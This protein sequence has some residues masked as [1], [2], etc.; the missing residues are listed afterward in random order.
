MSVLSTIYGT[1]I[2]YNYID[3]GFCAYAVFSFSRRSGTLVR[4]LRGPAA[5]VAAGSGKCKPR[6]SALCAE[7]G[8]PGATRA[9]R[10]SAAGPS[11]GDTRGRVRQRGPTAAD[12]DGAGRTFAH[13]VGRGRRPRPYLPCRPHGINA[14]RPV[15]MAVGPVWHC[16]PARST[17]RRRYTP[18]APDRGHAPT[19]RLWLDSD[20]PRY[21]LH[22]GKHAL[23]CDA[24]PQSVSLRSPLSHSPHN[25]ST[26]RLCL[27]TVRRSALS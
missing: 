12:G 6:H 14:I 23:I 11:L 17:S 22:R 5:T 8:T 9:A 10:W 3:R 27:S 1:G 26:L 15:E 4:V 16:P 19:A 20:A 21:D 18:A 2:K 24:R 7:C 13:P 25:L